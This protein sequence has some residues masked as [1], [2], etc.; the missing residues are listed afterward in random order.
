M[1]LFSKLTGKDSGKPANK[2]QKTTK[3]VEGWEVWLRD[4]GTPHTL[5]KKGKEWLDASTTWASPSGKFFVHEGHDGVGDACVALTSRAEGIKTKKLEEGVEAAIVTDDGVGYIFTDEGNLITITAE[6]ASQKS[7]GDRPAVGFVLTP[8]I[9]AAA[10][11]PEGEA[12]VVKAVEL[13]TGKSWQKKVKYE[14]AD[15]ARWTD[16][17]IEVDPGGITITTPDGN[18]KKFTF[19]GNEA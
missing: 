2:K 19:D 12:I 18:C 17:A 15:G 14:V 10:D 9:C 6:K 3:E 11:D 8:D 4:D 16:A 13:K 1:G 5:E 7:L